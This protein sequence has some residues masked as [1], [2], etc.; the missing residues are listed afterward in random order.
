MSRSFEIVFWFL[1]GAVVAWCAEPYLDRLI[2][3]IVSRV[4]AWYFKGR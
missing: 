2:H 3:A 4:A 1:Y